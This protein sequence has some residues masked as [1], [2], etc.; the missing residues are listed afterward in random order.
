MKYHLI[1]GL[2]VAPLAA[3]CG[4]FAAGWGILAWV[5]FLSWA[6]FFATGGNKNGLIKISLSTFVGY[7]GGYVAFE[8]ASMST[9]S[10]PILLP[11]TLVLFIICALGGFTIFFIP[12]A[13]LACA[14]YFG[15]GAL[16][17]E[18][19]ISLVLGIV[20][21][22]VSEFIA[23]KIYYIVDKKEHSTT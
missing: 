15:G 3:L 9:M 16:P 12:G 13:F 23:L 10:N 11:L 18:T 19:F 22:F 21:G 17:W 6:G 8:L 20:L 1:L 7:I 2:I 14:A 5:V 4:Q